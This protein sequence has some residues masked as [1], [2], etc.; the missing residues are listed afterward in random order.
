MALGHAMW[1]VGFIR[2][3]W[4]HAG[5]PCWALGSCGVVGFILGGTR[6]RP[7][8]RWVHPESLDPLGCALGVV[9]FIRSRWVHSGTPWGSLGS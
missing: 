6:V 8:G 4:F 3:R 9:A 1:V 5:G 2:G 7:G